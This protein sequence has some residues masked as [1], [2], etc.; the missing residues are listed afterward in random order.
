MTEA[1][2]DYPQCRITPLRMLKPDS[3][4]LLLNE[5][6][7]IPGILRMMINGPNLPRTVPYGPA[8]GKPNPNTNRRVISVKGSEFELRVQLG[9]IILEVRDDSVIEEIR[10]LCDR[11][12]T[13]FPYQLQTGKKYMRTQA[14]VADYAKYGPNVDPSLLGLTD[15][16]NKEGPV[17]IQGR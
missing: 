2:V 13:K 6:V 5:L 15:P 11:F 1:V 14:T 7:T 12:F 10:A 4:E 9:T 8:R 3:A 16:R 17:I